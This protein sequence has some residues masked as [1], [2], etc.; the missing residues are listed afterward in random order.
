MTPERRR[1]AKLL[2]LSTVKVLDPCLGRRPARR[3]DLGS[4]LRLVHDPKDVAAGELTAVRLA[5]AA[6]QQLGD[7]GRIAGDVPQSIR[8]LVGAVV[9]AANPDVADAGYLADM[10]DM[11][12]HLGKCRHGPGMAGLP[13]REQLL[14][15]PKIGRSVGRRQLPAAR[16]VAG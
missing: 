16:S 15:G 6:I 12:G 11:V 5:P 14:P 4:G 13:L 2:G 1:V 7:E 3:D 9:V 8:Q 10:I